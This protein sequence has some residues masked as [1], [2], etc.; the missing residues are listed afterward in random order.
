[1]SWF[2]TEW[3]VN[4][5]SCSLKGLR[6][7]GDW[8]WPL[9]SNLCTKSYPLATWLLNNVPI[10]FNAIAW[11][12]TMPLILCLLFLGSLCPP[13]SKV[14]KTMTIYIPLW[15]SA[16]ELPV[17]W[18]TCTFLC[19]KCSLYVWP[20]IASHD[21]VHGRVIHDDAWSGIIN[22]LYQHMQLQ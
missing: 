8:Q 16:W 13:Q 5:Q 7:F 9:R 3:E 19:P 22:F 18:F 12:S 20:N 10:K 15:F 11:L 14:W 21:H 17:I 1:M 4:E 6:Q 2:C